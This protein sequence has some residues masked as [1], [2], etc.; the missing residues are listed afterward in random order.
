MGHAVAPSSQTSLYLCSTEAVFWYWGGLCGFVCGGGGYMWGENWGGVEL[1]GGG[2]S[3][4]FAGGAAGLNCDGLLYDLTE[5]L[6]R[7]TVRFA[8]SDPTI[9]KTQT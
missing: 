8:I 6:T 4:L 1:Y 2:K 3:N 7:K 5:S 9:K